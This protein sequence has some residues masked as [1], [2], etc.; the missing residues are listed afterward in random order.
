MSEL[1]RFRWEP[2]VDGI[3]LTR[4]DR[5]GCNYEA[6]V[7]DYLVGRKFA[8]EG[9]VA[10]D[11]ADAERK[12]TELDRSAL[13]LADTEAFA[14]LLLR[15]ESVAS[16][17]I[18]GLEI[19]PRRLLQAD[20]AREDGETIN[21]VTAVEVLGNIDAMTY[22][23]ASIEEGAPITK[24]HVVETHR[25]LV[26]G[27]R[28]AKHAGRLRAVQNWIGGS[29]YNP[30]SASFVPP[31]PDRVDALL[32]D[33]VRFCN[34]D[35]LPTVAQAATAH[36]QFETIH[37]FV[38]GNGRVGRALIHM[39]LRRRGLAKRILPPISLVLATHA[40]DYVNALTRTRYLGDAK[41]AEAVESAND[42]IAL[43][44]GACVRAVVDAE[45]FEATVRKIKGHWRERLGPVRSHSAVQSL[46]DVLPGAPIIT[47]KSAA[48]LTKRSIPA[49][50]EAIARLER[51]EILQQPRARVWSRSF[52]VPEIID[53]FI[54]LERQLASP[55]GDTRIEAPVR[56]VP[57]WK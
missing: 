51:A 31:P 4:R 48:E 8:L 37:P 56:K 14:R 44:A 41:S 57:R 40:Q 3:S 50:N 36:A 47:V 29:S 27:T 19:G 52:E 2:Q 6:Y 26:S 7:P 11:V 39:V 55:A 20:A 9:T 30:C 22:A 25:R 5:L 42:W 38:D 43:F 23:A 32:D 34:D 46:L 45:A 12:I 15:A 17:R 16:S 54:G 35:S 18:E 53:A 24:E 21:D 33:F 49:V 28:L 1:L 10:A 13:A